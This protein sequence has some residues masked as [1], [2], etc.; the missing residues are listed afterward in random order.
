MTK[1]QRDKIA[2]LAAQFFEKT[3]DLMA[4]T[5]AIEAVIERRLELLAKWEK[6]EAQ[7][8]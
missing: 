5:F 2:A 1:E 7:A 3:E 8:R 6:Q 4:V